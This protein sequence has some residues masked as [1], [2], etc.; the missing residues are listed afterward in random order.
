MKE[1]PKKVGSE[2]QEV[3]SREQK[4]KARRRNWGA[5]SGQ[6]GAGSKMRR[7]K[8]RGVGNREGRH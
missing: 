3:R 5:E 4:Q 8:N 1:I 2:K 7:T 6:R